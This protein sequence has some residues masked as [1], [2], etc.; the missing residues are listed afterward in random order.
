MSLRV[1]T[2][3]FRWGLIL[4][5]LIFG[6]GWFWNILRSLQVSKG[7]RGARKS[8]PDD[9]NGA[10]AARLL[11]HLS[12]FGQTSLSIPFSF[13]FS[14]FLKPLFSFSSAVSFF[15]LSPHISVPSCAAGSTYKSHL[16]QSIQKKTEKK[17]ERKTET[18]NPAIPWAVT[19]QIRSG[20]RWLRKR[21]EEEKKKKPFATQSFSISDERRTSER[22][23]LWCLWLGWKPSCQTAAAIHWG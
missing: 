14:A 13:S 1:F 6:W 15:L 7:E 21:R 12:S 18:K 4:T 20:R 5:K 10:R 3:D 2:L 16:A 19:E 22:L 11:Q 9:D 17:K 8:E 23:R